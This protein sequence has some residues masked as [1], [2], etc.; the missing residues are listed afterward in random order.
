MY[1]YAPVLLETYVD[2]DRFAGTCYRAANWEQLGQTSG[3]GREAH[4][5]A[6]PQSIKDIYALL[7][8]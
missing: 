7:H 6:R 3:R 1:G 4:G 2:R 5:S 8:R